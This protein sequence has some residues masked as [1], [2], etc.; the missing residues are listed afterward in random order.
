[1]PEAISSRTWRLDALIVA[2]LVVGWVGALAGPVWRQR[3]VAHDTFRDSAYAEHCKSGRW[4]DDPTLLGYSYWYPPLGPLLYAQ[5]SRWTGQPALAVYGTSVL[6]FNVWILPLLYL[7][8]RCSF[9][10]LTGVTA[11]LM[12]WLGS[13]WWSDNLALP[14][15]AVQG[16]VPMLASLWAW[17]ACLRRRAIG[18]GAVGILLALC[19]WHHAVCGIAACGAVGLHAL[20]QSFAGN[21]AARR[22]T[23]IRAGIAGAVCGALVAPLAIH[24][25]TLPRRNLLPPTWIASEMFKAAYALQSGTPLVLPMGMVGAVPVLRRA[26]TPGGWALGL[27]AVGLVGQLPAYLDRWP[28]WHLPRLVPHEFQWHGQLGVCV[29]AA[30]AM[31][32]TARIAATRGRAALGPGKPSTPAVAWAWAWGI[33]LALL[34][35]PDAAAAVRRIDDRW[36]PRSVQPADRQAAEWIAANTGVYDVFLCEPETAYRVV[37]A[38]T[39]RKAVASLPGYSNIAAP[40]DS[41]QTACLN[42]LHEQE[43]DHFLPI[44]LRHRVSYVYARGDLRQHFELWRQWGAF[45]EVFTSADKTVV[46]LRLRD[47]VTNQDAP[48]ADQADHPTGR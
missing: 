8:V 4:F 25:L 22:N 21:P 7:L 37:G 23:W 6:W 35:G 9:D 33:L 42:L 11:V 16:L 34:L 44:A 15:P 18:A 13:R 45:D 48:P 12:V 46:I 2:V 36:L 41:L 24:L 20:L 38:L 31:V 28:G 40:V 5:L 43:L 30:V 3:P 14:I 10:R 39:G 19:T 27:S 26:R 32:W 1:L 17:V 29:L 47:A